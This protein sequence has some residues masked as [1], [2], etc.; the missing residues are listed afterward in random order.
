VQTIEEIEARR[1]HDILSMTF[2]IEQELLRDLTAVLEVLPKHLEKQTE[3]MD[4]ALNKALHDFGILR[5]EWHARDAKGFNNEAGNIWFERT[6]HNWVNSKCTF[7]GASQAHDR[8]ASNNSTQNPKA[9]TETR[10]RE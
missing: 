3:V 7:C 8:A 2:Y 9:H 10:L 1:K 4:Q 5:K 6:E